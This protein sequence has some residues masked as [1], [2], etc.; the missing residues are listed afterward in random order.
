M[1]LLREWLFLRNGYLRVRVTGHAAERFLNLCGANG[2][3][4]WN[5]VPCGD[6]LMC[7]MTVPAFRRIRPLAKKAGVRVRILRRFGI[8]FFI[9]RNRRR[10]GLYTGA[11]AFFVL[12]YVLS[13]F[14]WNITFEGNYHYSRDTLLNYLETLNVRCGMR[15]SLVSCEN[16]E[17]SLRS[18]FPEIT[19]VS[20]SISGT[21]LFVRVKENEALSA[22]P[23]QDSAP[24]RLV[25]DHSGTITRMIVRQG[26]AA[27]AVGDTVEKGQELVSSE[28]SVMN[29]SG[30]TVRYMNVRADADVYA[31][32]EYAYRK[33]IPGF[34]KASS[35]TGRKRY[36]L[37]VTF[38]SLRL[39]FLAPAK[40]ERLWDYVSE[41][42]QLRLF[43]DFY[44]PVY[45]ETI[46]G[47]EYVSYERF[48]TKQE[49]KALAQRV[50]D[51]YLENLMEKG[52]HIIENNVK[53]QRDGL[54]FV[55]EGTVTAE[56]QIAAAAPVESLPEESAP[57]ETQASAS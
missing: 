4:V 55:I 6:G 24:C 23:Q 51:Q 31:R 53:I 46:T 5:L 32:T 42:R 48:Y 17:E 45:G 40:K 34:Y 27:A 20:A 44:L 12:I 1:E 3:D 38:G 14:V 22:I 26:R 57:E 49:I 13:L 43:E 30:E 21:R 9:S 15:K 50:H 18:A 33:T 56:E 25:A 16:L 28:L 52:V 37:A 2:M 8:P 7:C 19:W 36:G 47:N 39:G 11:A 54:S 35:D 10:V 29:D 41:S